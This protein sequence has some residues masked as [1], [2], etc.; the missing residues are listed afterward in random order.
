[1]EITKLHI[2]D[3]RALVHE[4]GNKSRFVFFTHFTALLLNKWLLLHPETCN[5]VFVSMRTGNAL[6]DSGIQQMLKRLKKQAK[7]KG[8]VNPH[9]FRHGFAREYIKNGGDLATL[10]RLLGHSDESITA[11]YYAVFAPDELAEFHKKHS[12]IN[13]LT[14]ILRREDNE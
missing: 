13:R 9:S 3:K 1:L 7:V 12:P 5:F 6:T 8:R 4:K 14:K 2:N 11:A 10:A